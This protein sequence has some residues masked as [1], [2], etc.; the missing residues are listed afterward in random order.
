MSLSINNHKRVAA[1]ALLAIALVSGCTL[2]SWSRNQPTTSDV[3][4]SVPLEVNLDVDEKQLSIGQHSLELT[5]ISARNID[6]AQGVILATGVISLSQTPPLVWDYLPAG[7]Q[8][9]V[10]I[11][12]QILGPGE[13]E[14]QADIRVFNATGEFLYGRADTLYLL[15]TEKEV[16]VDVIS[17]MNLKLKKL[18]SDRKSGVITHEEYEAQR[19]RILGGGATITIET[20]APSPTATP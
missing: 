13:G 6:R 17:P 12:I 5:V 9:K 3:K 15:A 1:M 11:P 8:Q 19:D 4:T 7:E 18:E 14:I 16:L 2:D 20:Q 10:E